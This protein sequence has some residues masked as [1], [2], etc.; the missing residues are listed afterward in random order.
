MECEASELQERR[1]RG[2]V[3]KYGSS[4]RKGGRVTSN[5]VGDGTTESVDGMRINIIK[6]RFVSFDLLICSLL[7]L[8]LFHFLLPVPLFLLSTLL[9]LYQILLLVFHDFVHRSSPFHD[10]LNL[11]FLLPP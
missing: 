9:S 4:Q 7:S 10:V 2:G 1:K 3:R 6:P 8:L 5:R 11:Q